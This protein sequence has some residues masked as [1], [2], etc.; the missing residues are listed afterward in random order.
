MPFPLGFSYV[1]A[2]YQGTLEPVGFQVEC[3][4]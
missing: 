3:L 4:I 1:P 2:L